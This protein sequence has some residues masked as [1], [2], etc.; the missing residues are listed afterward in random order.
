ME[1]ALVGNT[2]QPTP[3]ETRDV[4]K[5]NAH[6]EA[7]AAIKGDKKWTVITEHFDARIDYYRKGLA[8]I[9]PKNLSNAE[10][11]EKY[12]VCESIAAELEGLKTYVEEVAR[13]VAEA[14]RN[15]DK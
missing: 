7:V 4:E 9:D 2:P 13:G 15:K 10:V 8:G 11:G 12:L 3:Q 1:D 5:F 14:R 6:D